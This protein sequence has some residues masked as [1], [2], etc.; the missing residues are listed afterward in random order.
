MIGIMLHPLS[1]GV[2][3]R[4][5]LCSTP[6]LNR[7]IIKIPYFPAKYKRICPEPHLCSIDKSGRR[8]MSKS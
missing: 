4:L 1:V 2:A 8:K 7:T 6:V 5:P 3:D